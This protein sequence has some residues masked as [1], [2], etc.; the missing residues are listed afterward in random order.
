MNPFDKINFDELNALQKSMSKIDETVPPSWQTV[1]QL[2]ILSSLL[3]RLTI[4][5]QESEKINRK[6]F[7][8]SAVVSSVAAFASVLSVVFYL[9]HI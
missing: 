8:F 6:R 5:I 7:L 3:K 1:N 9:F 2:S 4:D